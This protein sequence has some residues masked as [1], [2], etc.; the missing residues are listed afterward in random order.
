MKNFVGLVVFLLTAS[1]LTAQVK[2]GQFLLNLNF[3]GANTKE[4]L[5]SGSTSTAIDEENSVDVSLILLRQFTAKGAWGVFLGHD[6]SGTKQVSANG[7]TLLETSTQG[8]SVGPAYRK[9]FSKSPLVNIYTDFTLIYR[10]G[11]TGKSEF[12]GGG[13]PLLQRADVDFNQY[14]FNL[15][16][17]AQIG[18]AKNLVATLSFELFRA[19]YF[20]QNTSISDYDGTGTVIQSGQVGESGS[21]YSFF[22][23]FSLGSLSIGVQLIVGKGKDE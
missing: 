8:Y 12:D 10:F 9:L 5:E 18:V 3:T 22:P 2:P 4:D 14:T 20:D 11:D 15:R 21:N 17:G 1:G 7:G 16:P 19:V 6:Y 23:G 13:G